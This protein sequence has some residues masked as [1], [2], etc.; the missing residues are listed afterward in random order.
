MKLI[1]KLG[2]NAGAGTDQGVIDDKD[3]H[4]ANDRDQ[5]AV[6]I[7]TG[8]THVAKGVKEPAAYDGAD[9]SQH[10]VQ[11]HAFAAFIDDFAGDETCNE[12]QNDPS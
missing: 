6:K 9:D 4:S 1:A 3:D 7:Q 8:N 11:D 2:L 5:D 10:N 12:P